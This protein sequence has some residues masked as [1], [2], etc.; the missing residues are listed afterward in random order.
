M[1]DIPSEIPLPLLTFSRRDV[2]RPQVLR[3]AEVIQ[4]AR[5]LVEGL[6]PENITLDVDTEES[7]GAVR[8]DPSQLD[9]VLLNLI[10]NAAKFTEDGDIRLDVTMEEFSIISVWSMA[11]E[12]TVNSFNSNLWLYFVD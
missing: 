8:V 9:Q 11:K 5:Q 3:V 4:E 7:A 12:T 6:L 2:V 1:P 10:A